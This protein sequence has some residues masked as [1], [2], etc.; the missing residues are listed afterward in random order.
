M[1]KRIVYKNKPIYLPFA[2]ADYGGD[3]INELETVQ[4]PFSG[5][6]IALPKFAVAVYDVIM[7]SNMIAEKYDQ[8]HGSGTSPAWNDVRKGLNWF[9]QHFAKEYMVLLD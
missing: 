5:Q 8:V 1:K 4:N 9:R 7:G 6:S 2:D 3:E